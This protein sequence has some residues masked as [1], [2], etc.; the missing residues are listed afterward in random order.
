MVSQKSIALPLQPQAKCRSQNS[1][2]FFS[3]CAKLAEPMLAGAS[4]IIAAYLFGSLPY[5]VSLARAK[6][7]DLSQ[8]EDLHRALWQKVG[9]VEGLSGILVD[10]SK[11][12]IPALIGFGFGLSPMVV[13]LSCVAAT[14]GQM[15]P[16]F[17]HFDGEKGNSI[18]VAVIFALTLAYGTYP[19]FL[20]LIPI[21]TGAGIR[22]FSTLFSTKEPFSERIKFHKTTTPIALCLPVGMILG[23]A[24]AP[25]A[26]WRFGQPREITLCLLLLFLLIL[27]RRLT[28]SLRADL[29]ASNSVTRV[30]ISHLVLD[31]AL[32]EEIKNNS[33]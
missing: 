5:M 23:F 1:F 19:V 15:W 26:S 24:A 14:A 2:T 9:I 18:G 8:D 17:Y 21:V 33:K 29:K 11:G 27:L 30:L 4:L 12:A 28:A 10:F 13:G 6:G 31:R 20:F 7:L 16:V 32:A 25:L 22:F 3:L